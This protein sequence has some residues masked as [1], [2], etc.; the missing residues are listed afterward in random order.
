[1]KKVLLCLTLAMFTI[2]IASAGILGAATGT[3][4]IGYNGVTDSG[5]ALTPTTVFTFGGASVSGNGT[6]NFDCV[7]AGPDSVCNGYG[8][9][10][11]SG[12]FAGDNSIGQILTFDGGPATGTPQYQYVITSQDAPAINSVGSITFYQINTNGNFSDLRGTNGFD[13]AAASLGITIVQNCVSPGNCSDSASAAFATPPAF[14]T[15]P[16]PATLALI[17][18]ALLCLGFVRRRKA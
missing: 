14:F 5:G 4:P 2:S 10:F 3:V 16:E 17:G 18:S 11:L 7:V 9:T 12:I 15:T 13:T 6:G 1:M 8:A